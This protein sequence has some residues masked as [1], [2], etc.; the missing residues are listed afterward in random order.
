MSDEI[1]RIARSRYF[2]AEWYAD[3][4]P[5]V[6]VSGLDPAHHYLRFGAYLR[7][8]PHPDLDPVAYRICHPGMKP[9][10]PVLH[11]EAI[12]GPLERQIVYDPNYVLSAAGAIMAAGELGRA[13]AFARDHLPG[14][15]ADRVDIFDA[16]EA[17]QTG[18]EARWLKIINRYVTREG[19]APIT[20]EHG[21]QPLFHRLSTDPVPPVTDGPLVSV[22]MAVWN[23]GDLLERSIRS[24]LNQSHRN[25]EL[26]ICDDCSTDDSWPTLQRLASEDPRIRLL[27]NAA[28]VGPY[29]SKNRAARA[30]SGAYLTGQDSDDWSHPERIARHLR[31]LT[32]SDLPASMM[33]TIRLDTDGTPTRLSPIGANSA[34]GIV[35]GGFINLM[36]RARFFHEALGAWDSVRFAADSEIVRRITR[37]TGQPVPRLNDPLTFFADLPNSLTNDPVSG[38]SP[39]FGMTTPRQRYRDELTRWHDTKRPRD[40]VM[41]FPQEDRPFPAP[42]EALNPPE[43]VTEALTGHAPP[44]RRRTAKIAI[45]TDTVFP[46][47][48]TSST[49]DEM[50]YFAAQGLEPILIHCGCDYDRGRPT[51]PRYG[52]LAGKIVEPYTFDHLTVDHLI[53]RNP[54]VITHGH[55]GIVAPKIEARHAFFVINNSFQRP[56]DQIVY[57]REHLLSRIDSVNAE[58]KEICPIGPLIRAEIEEAVRSRPDAPPL[59]DLDWTPTFDAATYLAE[60]KPQMTAPYRIGRHGRDAHEKWLEDPEQLLQAYPDHE[61]V[62]VV[63]LGGAFQPFLMLGCLP[64]NWEDHPFGS[65]DPKEYLSGLDAFVYF[66]DTDYREAFGRTII[67][68]MIAGLPCLLPHQFEETFGDLPFYLPPSGVLPA[69]RALAE[70]DAARIAHL[71]EIQDLALQLYG[72]DVIARR[73]PSLFPSA[74]EKPNATLSKTA[75]AYKSHIETSGA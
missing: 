63:I 22:L 5:D 43:R 30:A 73:L 49:V 65:I 47:G 36:V 50:R 4:Y 14:R 32:A 42:P 13:R 64:S 41:S 46:G 12:Y 62:R 34:D 48:N 40:L 61:D 38:Y 69:L 8:W 15:M 72:T 29:V 10:N 33:G 66:P 51:T 16:V 52:D 9:K 60:P 20:L 45:L 18:E 35:T 24:I 68:A 27:R 55:F 44:D 39:K 59:S 56:P 74:S 17:A 53:I 70:D 37:I 21:G 26:L 67:E 31:Q 6:A 1:E 3:R 23:G 25:L 7:R 75:R 11:A 58:T 57:D 19:A 54:S 71:K 28:N 2:D